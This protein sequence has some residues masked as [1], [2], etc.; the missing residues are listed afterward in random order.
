MEPGGLERALRQ[1]LRCCAHLLPQGGSCVAL[2]KPPNLSERLP[3][4]TEHGD[5]PSWVNAW[6]PNKG[7][8]DEG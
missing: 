1:E 6:D 3:S 5:S 7:W 8:G 4:S 2:G